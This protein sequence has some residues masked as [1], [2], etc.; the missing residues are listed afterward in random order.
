MKD[1]TINFFGFI[2]AVDTLIIPILFAA[3]GQ[4]SP[5]T[6]FYF[7][8]IGL[9][10]LAA[11]GSI[12]SRRRP[13]VPWITSGILLAFVILGGFSIGF[14]LVPGLLA[15]SAAGTL[16]HG[17]LDKSLLSPIGLFLLTGLVQAAFMLS[18]VNFF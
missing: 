6:V 16:W 2:G 11:M 8:E 12:F 14:Y 3:Q 5:I 1:R 9:A 7:T 15:F 18:V 10:G 17:R 13:L 4:L